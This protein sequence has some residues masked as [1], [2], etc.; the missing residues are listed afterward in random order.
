MDSE[1]NINNEGYNGL[2]IHNLNTLSTMMA[3]NGEKFKARAYK[4]AEE[5]IALYPTLITNVSQ[6]ASLP[7]IGPSILEKLNELA[8]T[9]KI[10]QI[11]ENFNTPYAKFI[12]IYGVGPKKAME[13]VNKYNITTIEDLRFNQ[14]K[15]LNDTQMVGL[16]YYED[17]LK[18]IQREEIEAYKGIFNN[19]F[20]AIQQKMYPTAPLGSM[21]KFE[22]VGSYRRGAQESGDIDVIL[23]G[24]TDE[25]GVMVYNLLIDVLKSKNIILNILARGD[26]KCLVIAKLPNQQYARRVDFLYAPIEQYAFSILYFTGS[27]LFNTM[28]RQHALDMGY[29]LNEHGISRMIDGVKDTKLI[30][31]FFPDEKSIFDFFKMDYQVPTNRGIMIKKTAGDSQGLLSSLKKENETL[32]NNVLKAQAYKD[33]DTAVNQIIDKKQVVQKKNKIENGNGNKSNNTSADKNKMSTNMQSKQTNMITDFRKGG[34]SVLNKYSEADLKGLLELASAAYYN[35]VAIMSDNEYDILEAYAKEKYNTI[36]VVGSP[37]DSAKTKARLPYEMASMDKIKPDTGALAAWKSKYAGESVISCKLDGVSGLYYNEGPLPKL[38]T[39]GDGK[40]GQ[41]I[42]H[43][44]PLFNLPTE[45]GITMRG[46][47][48]IPKQVFEARFKNEFANPRNTV[49]GLLNHKTI[50]DSLRAKLQSVRF[51]AYELIKPAL[52]PSEQFAFLKRIN[53]ETSAHHAL[54]TPQLTNE[55]L[56]QWLV[57][58]RE[59]Y[60]YEIDGIVVTDDKIYQRTAGNPAHAFAFKMVLSDQCAEA[61]VVDVI[62]SPSKDGYLKPRVQI[63]PIMLCGVKIEY[64]TGF[65]AGFIKQNKI[66]VGSLIQIIRS[67]DVIPHIT[68]V[69]VSSAEPKMPDCEYDWTDTGVDIILKDASTNDTVVEKN[70]TMFFKG[71]E[72]EGLSSGTVNKLMKA[73]YNTVPKIIKMKKEDVAKIDG[74]GAK[75]AEKICEGIKARMQSASIVTLMAASNIFGRGFGERKLQ[76]IMEYFPFILVSSETKEEKIANV[77]QVKGISDK[78]AELFVLNIE[79]FNKFLA[80]CGLHSGH[81]QPSVLPAPHEAQPHPL[82]KKTIVLTGFRDKELLQKLKDVGAIVGASVTKNTFA[83]VTKNKSN[84]DEGEGSTKTDAAVKLGIPIFS[85]EEF[86]IHNHF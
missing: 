38:Y 40:V 49:A 53:M 77:L 32:L 34:I 11:D 67:G 39:R 31:N 60:V 2:F 55:I 63:E 46:E 65:N 64:A 83:V 5:A 20:Q 78:S 9:G 58:K 13:I 44:L 70:I 3:S 68:S 7:G 81:A 28:M 86:K 82:N 61:K 71:I 21:C 18:R 25:I 14:A 75:S 85:L 41:D 76:P 50:D 43:L 15:V 17:L 10:A 45:K 52:K 16:K 74:L 42:S 12:D 56:S 69:T 23:T 24:K 54:S 6:I 57:N 62:W 51:V 1:N 8:I 35:H 29:T 36:C 72:V 84:A 26:A 80:D 37:V 73:G 79:P 47:F 33:D 4:K 66:G 19:V 27:K 30:A 48:I 59:E 22:I